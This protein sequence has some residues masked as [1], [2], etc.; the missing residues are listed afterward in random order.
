VRKVE[1]ELERLRNEGLKLRER[2]EKVESRT[3]ITRTEAAAP[4][5]PP[6]RPRPKVRRAPKPPRGPRRR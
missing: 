3:G 4:P 1:E 5:E 2:L 6:K